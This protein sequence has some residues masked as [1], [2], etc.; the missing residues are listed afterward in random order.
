MRS[1]QKNSF[2]KESHASFKTEKPFYKYF[3]FNPLSKK[4]RIASFQLVDVS[5]LISRQNDPLKKR[6]CAKFRNDQISSDLQQE[7]RLT[8]FSVSST[9]YSLW[10]QVPFELWFIMFEVGWTLM[11]RSTCSLELP[12]LFRTSY[13]IK[14]SLRK[15]YA[16]LILIRT[17]GKIVPYILW[18]YHGWFT[19]LDQFL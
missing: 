10:H 17:L 14:I 11:Y 4:Q 15:K 18:N 8:C 19:Y 7:L 6:M 13:W 9:I 16:D 1:W 12:S 3:I 5:S 2:R